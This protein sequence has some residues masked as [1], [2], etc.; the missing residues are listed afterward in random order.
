MHQDV[1]AIWAK[2]KTKGG[3][4]GG[5]WGVGGEWHLCTLD[6]CLVLLHCTEILKRF[7]NTKWIVEVL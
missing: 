2:T 7:G 6:A 5:G 1:F 3:V 4:G